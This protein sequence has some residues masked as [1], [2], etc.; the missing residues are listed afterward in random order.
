MER[1]QRLPLAEVELDG[2]G[3]AAVEL[4]QV[5]GEP[6]SC[7]LGVC[8]LRL[9]HLLMAEVERQEEVVRVAV[10]G[11][12]AEVAEEFEALPRLRAALRMVAQT[13]DAVV[14]LSRKVVQH[15]AKGD[16]VS[17]DVREERDLQA[18][19]GCAPGTRAGRFASG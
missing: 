8:D 4:E 14:L 17:V 11:G 19:S 2:R 12:A 10:D 9:R 16:A 13:E 15:R 18:P 3:E 1:E 6:R 7:P 5:V